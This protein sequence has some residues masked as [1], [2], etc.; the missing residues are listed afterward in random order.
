MSVI[1][2]LEDRLIRKANDYVTH[3]IDSHEPEIFPIPFFS[4]QVTAK[5]FFTPLVEYFSDD[6][7][8]SLKGHLF[9]GE[10]ITLERSF[11]VRNGLDDK[12]KS[13]RRAHNVKKE[14][15]RMYSSVKSEFNLLQIGEIMDFAVIEPFVGDVIPATARM[16]NS[17]Y[18]KFLQQNPIFARF[19]YTHYLYWGKK[20][21]RN[22]LN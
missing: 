16:N 4:S 19:H 10:I 8:P 20:H 5:D 17:L 14:D 15:I 2:P 6:H 22:I 11:P 7:L 21:Y 3:F 13:L 1:Q 18:R 12:I 9:V